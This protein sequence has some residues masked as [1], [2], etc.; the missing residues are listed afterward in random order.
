MGEG[1]GEV[2]LPGHRVDEDEAVLL[3]EE[4][5]T[6]ALGGQLATR[7]GEGPGLIRN[8]AQ[9]AFCVLRGLEVRRIGEDCNLGLRQG[10]R[11][12]NVDIGGIFRHATVVKPERE[13]LAGNAFLLCGTDTAPGAFSGIEGDAER[14]RLPRDGV[15]EGAM[16]K[17]GGGR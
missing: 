17:R 10:S 9:T 11:G 13:D 4:R 14:D 7:D 12:D 2:T 5:D 3:R 15:T 1:P 16:N 8:D 6:G